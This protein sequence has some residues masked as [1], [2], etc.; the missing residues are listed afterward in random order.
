M[1]ESIVRNQ[2]RVLPCSV[3]LNGEFGV[4]A[5]FVGVPCRLGA[6]GMEAIYE[7][8]LSTSEKDA[9]QKSVAANQELMGVAKT[10]MG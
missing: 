6:A 8:E 1:V 7:F 4:K 9:F 2:H 10:A 5:C 3:E